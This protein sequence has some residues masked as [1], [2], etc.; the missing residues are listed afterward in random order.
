MIIHN[1]N[2]AELAHFITVF[3]TQ[4]LST[5]FSDTG[6]LVLHLFSLG[7]LKSLLLQLI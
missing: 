1:Q 6:I 2:F 5:F 4:E 3:Y 7:L